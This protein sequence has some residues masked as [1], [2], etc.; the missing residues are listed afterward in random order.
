MHQAFDFLALSNNLSATFVGLDRIEQYDYKE[1]SIR[2]GVLNA[3]IHRDYS[4][5]GSI[6]VN[7]YNDRIEFVS[8]GGIIPGLRIEDLFLGVS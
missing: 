5:S 6:I 1:E 7:L 3:I 4:F 8:L 2:E